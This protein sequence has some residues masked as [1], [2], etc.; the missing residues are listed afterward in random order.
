ML[1]LGFISEETTFLMNHCSSAQGYDTNF[2]W[3]LAGWSSGCVSR[4]CQESILTHKFCDIIYFWINHLAPSVLSRVI[5]GRQMWLLMLLPLR[6]AWHQGRAVTSFMEWGKWN[7]Q[8][9]TDGVY[10][11]WFYPLF[12]PAAAALRQLLQCCSF[13]LCRGILE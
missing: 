13:V 4:L 11:P 5:T 8:H 6:W 3:V 12:S 7:E 2:W 10:K 9:N 1:L